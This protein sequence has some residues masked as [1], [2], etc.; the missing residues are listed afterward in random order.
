M[1]IT[2]QYVELQLGQICEMVA[3]PRRE[4]GY[5]D[6]C[7]VYVAQEALG[8]AR[9]FET[10]DGCQQCRDV[11]R[12]AG[13]TPDCELDQTDRD[14]LEAGRIAGSLARGGK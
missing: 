8:K 13:I 11:A 4:T 2:P 1:K 3:C 14:I 6:G 9:D 10:E 7:P 12:A 5:C